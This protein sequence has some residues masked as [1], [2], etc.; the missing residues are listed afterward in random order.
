MFRRK[1]RYLIDQNGE[2]R[3]IHYRQGSF[4]PNFRRSLRPDKAN[5]TAVEINGKWVLVEVDGNEQ[6]K[7]VELEQ[8]VHRR[9][10]LVVKSLLATVFAFAA[11]NGP[12]GYNWIHPVE[13][14]L[15][16]ALG[17]VNMTG[18]PLHL[19]EGASLLLLGLMCLAMLYFASRFALS[20]AKFLVLEILYRL[21]FPYM[22]GARA[23][24]LPT[25]PRKP[26][27]TPWNAMFEDP[28]DAARQMAASG[29][30]THAAPLAAPKQRRLKAS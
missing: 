28:M 1:P 10:G 27:N 29:P 6:K 19:T 2:L 20:G 21:G 15:T 11:W 5:L 23:Q 14:S 3:H 24:L 12:F 30:G 25:V 13:T 9:Q 8:A 7:T 18:V 22:K 17:K 4:F 26:I 16:A